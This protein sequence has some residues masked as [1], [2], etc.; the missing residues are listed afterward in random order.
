MFARML[1]ENPGQSRRIQLPTKTVDNFVSSGRK[2]SARPLLTGRSAKCREIDQVNNRPVNLRTVL[3]ACKKS[4][5][6]T[7]NNIP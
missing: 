2:G 5:T 1:T 3:E 4:P 7:V 6:P